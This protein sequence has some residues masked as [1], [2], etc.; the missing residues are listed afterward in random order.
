M[1]EEILKLREEGK[2]Y[3]EIVKILNCSKGTVSYYCG[4]N[5]KEKTKERTKK[6]RNRHTLVQKV[7]KF[8]CAKFREK[9]RG[10]QRFRDG[11]SYKRGGGRDFNFNWTDVLK[12]IGETPICYLTGRKIDLNKPSE[13]NLDHITPASR[14]GDNSLENL[15]VVTAEANMAKNNMTN[16]EFIELCKDVLKHHGYEIKRK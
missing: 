12:K 1:E 11:G 8:K 16:E 2:S 4:K 9:C 15:G 13:Y 7:E 10:F 6:R 5:Q 14:G 3:N